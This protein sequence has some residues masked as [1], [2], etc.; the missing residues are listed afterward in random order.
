MHDALCNIY[1][2]VSFQTTGAEVGKLE[3]HVYFRLVAATDRSSSFASSRVDSATTAQVGEQYEAF[4]NIHPPS[5][6]FGEP[7]A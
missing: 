4:R 1:I 5:S 6:G 3:T 2:L 7:S